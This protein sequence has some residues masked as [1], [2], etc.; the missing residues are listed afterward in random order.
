MA[1]ETKTY[2]F[3]NDG[4]GLGNL[5]PGML[6]GAG[7][8]NGGFGGAFGANS[9][10]DL[11]ALAIVASIFGWG[12]NGGFGFGGNRGGGMAGAGFL[13]NQISDTSTRDIILQAINGTDADVRQLAS[14]WNVDVESVKTGINTVNSAIAS[15]AAQNGVSAMQIVNSIQSGNATLGRQLCECCCENRLLTTQ[16]GYESRIATIEQT[17]QLGSQADRNTRSITDAIAALQTNM[18]K[19]FCDVKERELQNKIEALTAS[20]TVLRTQIDNAAQTAQVAAM[21]API[22]AKL[23]EIEGK[24]PNTVPVQWPNLVAVNTTPNPYSG[25]YGGYNGYGY[26]VNGGSY[27][28]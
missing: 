10:G 8:G 25:F 5:V 11:V 20:N 2:V 27:W 19:E 16:Q 24:Q 4:A 9:I 18:T 21:L 13:S 15:L 1:E 7:L 3:G 17:N 14:T 28:G 23:V 6:M 26:G 12:G 22:N